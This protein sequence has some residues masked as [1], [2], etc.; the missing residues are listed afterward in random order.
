VVEVLSQTEERTWAVEA[1]L[2]MLI[3][4]EGIVRGEGR[5]VV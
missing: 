3:L 2:G 5:K 1:L 4:V